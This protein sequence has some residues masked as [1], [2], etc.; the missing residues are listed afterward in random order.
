MPASGLAPIFASPAL[1]LLHSWW[2]LSRDLM[3]PA[4]EWFAASIN[5][6]LTRILS[7]AHQILQSACRDFIIFQGQEMMPAWGS[8]LQ[9]LRSGNVPWAEAHPAEAA[10]GRDFW[11]YLEVHP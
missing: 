7:A 5:A 3:P 6:K 4:R 9:G 1:F 11:G 2:S 10:A 8:L